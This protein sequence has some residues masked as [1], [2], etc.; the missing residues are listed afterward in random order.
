M[1]SKKEKKQGLQ[2]YL[3]PFIWAGDE[4]A[5][6]E[7][8]KTYIRRY[9]A[10]WRK[11]KR[12]SQKTFEI[13]FNADEYKVIKQGKLGHKRSFTNFIKASALAYCQRRYLIPDQL[14]YNM[15]YQALM[16]GYN[17]LKDLEDIEKI[18][19][20]YLDELIHLF[21]SMENTIGRQ[22]KN[23]KTFEEVLVEA[24]Q[25]DPLYKTKIIQ[26]LQTT[27]R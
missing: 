10:A 23:P 22:L 17:K 13:S 24:V 3:E 1:K 11:E 5:I 21:S 27:E 7:A 18:P 8:R 6:S 4:Q 15:V 14:A 19:L 20:E 12:K 26:L 2:L 9:K 25:T 16:M